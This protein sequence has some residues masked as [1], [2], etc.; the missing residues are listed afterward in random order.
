MFDKINWDDVVKATEDGYQYVTTTP[1]HPYGEDRKDRDK[2][3][4]YLHR[5]VMEKHLGRY[6]KENEEVHHKN[7]DPTDNRISNLEIIKRAAHARQHAKKRKFWKKSP[8]NK[9]EDKDASLRVLHLFLSNSDC[10]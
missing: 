7:D 3:Y 10:R 6:L 8:E 5:A 4:V 9:P 1:S 2:K